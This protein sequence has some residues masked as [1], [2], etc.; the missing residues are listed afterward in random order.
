MKKNVLE[1]LEINIEFFFTE[2][3]IIFIV[4]NEI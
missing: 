2:S 4:S 1:I 3:H